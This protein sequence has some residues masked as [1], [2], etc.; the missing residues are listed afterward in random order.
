MKFLER[1]YLA[2]ESPYQN[3]KVDYFNWNLVSSNGQL[4]LNISPFTQILLTNGQ[5]FHPFFYSQAPNL[6]PRVL[7]RETHYSNGS[8]IG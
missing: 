6:P 7:Y 1:T 5:A 8:V 2:K 3:V 4:K